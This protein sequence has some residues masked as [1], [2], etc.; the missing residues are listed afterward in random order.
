ML[1][2]MITRGN[3]KSGLLVLLGAA[4]FLSAFLLFCSEP[5]IGKMMLPL[6]RRLLQYAH[7]RSLEVMI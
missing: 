3:E 6:D 4:V 5:M 2:T 7:Y 1:S